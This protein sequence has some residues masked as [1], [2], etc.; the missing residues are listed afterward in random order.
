M[1]KLILLTSIF[2]SSQLYSQH[3]TAAAINV[4]TNGPEISPT[5]A[6][7]VLRIELTKSNMYNVLDKQDLIEVINK[8][9]I[10]IQDCFGKECLHSVGAA[11]KVDKIF[12]GSI[13]QIGKR[14]VVTIKILDIA[15]NQ[16]D[17]IVS[18]EFINLENEIQLMVHITLNKALGIENEK[19]LLEKLVYYNEP[20]E[21]PTTKE[22]NSGPRM[23]IVFIGGDLG[24]V[25]QNPEE[26]GGFDVQPVMSQFGYQLEKTYLSSGNFQ[27]LVEGM[28]MFTGVEQGMFNP[29][30]V[31]MNGF[32]NS[33]TGLEF[34]FGP[35]FNLKREARGYFDE[36]KD[37]HL[38]NE[39]ETG[40]TEYI[41]TT[42]ANG[43]P[44]TTANYI[45]TPNPHSLTDRVDSRGDLKLN[46]NWVWAIGKTFHSGYLNI[47][48]NAYFS[49]SKNGWMTGLSVGFNI[50]TKKG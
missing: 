4:Y 37:W 31:F 1:K 24:T 41:D 35:S 50:G 49:H 15:S 11:A 29:S 16:Y 25:L 33:K 12:T 3:K 14:V 38:A 26:D 17:K 36:N 2:I 20:L 8:N 28:V 10:T 45:S 18:E 5:E 32:R 39:W 40:H 34:A 9:R 43:N 46:A 27:A 19:E 47:P 23:G 22:S 21:L 48:V 42:D 6:E 7:S 13:E 30:L 44:Y